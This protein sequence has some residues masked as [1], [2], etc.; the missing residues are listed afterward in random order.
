[1]P[2]GSELVP[3]FSLAYSAPRLLASKCRLACGVQDIEVWPSLSAPHCSDRRRPVGLRAPALCLPHVQARIRDRPSWT[4]ALEVAPFDVHFV[5]RGR[6]FVWRVEPTLF[7][8]SVQVS[9]DPI[10]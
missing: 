4:F 6:P 2:F 8:D 3:R 5:D 7:S 9:C 10:D 1:M